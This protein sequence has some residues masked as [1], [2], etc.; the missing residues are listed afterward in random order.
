[1]ISGTHTT[2]ASRKT[3]ERESF[4]LE[5]AKAIRRELPSTILMVTGGFRSRSGMGQA[6]ADGSCDIIGLA[7]PA[8]LNPS[9][10]K[11]ILLNSGVPDEEAK[12]DAPTISTPWLLKQIGVKALGAGAETVST[13][14]FQPQQRA[15]SSFKALVYEE[16]EEDGAIKILKPLSCADETGEHIRSALG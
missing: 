13:P 3:L 4:F 6:I 14:L 11:N 10:P 8:I 15:H 16:N 12:V 7:R 9:I 5:F 1:M 2:A